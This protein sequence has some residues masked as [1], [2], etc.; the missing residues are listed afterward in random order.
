MDVADQIIAIGPDIFNPQDVCNGVDNLA[1]AF[2][3]R[4]CIDLD[5]DR[6]NTM[7]WLTAR[8]LELLEYEVK[9][10]G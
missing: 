10:L 8:D 2:K 4:M 1:E 6:Q 3:G 5:F 7:C 9:T